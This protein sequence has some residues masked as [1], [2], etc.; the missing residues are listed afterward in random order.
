LRR[1]APRWSK[2]YEK[3]CPHDTDPASRHVKMIAEALRGKRSPLR[4]AV[5]AYDPD[6]L[7]SSLE[8]TVLELWRA[9]ARIRELEGND[10]G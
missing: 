2:V 8:T 4:A 6:H 5:M 10:N 9:R 7:A 3:H 1:S